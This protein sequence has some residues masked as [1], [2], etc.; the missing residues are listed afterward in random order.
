[1]TDEEIKQL[2][3]KRKKLIS[4]RRISNPNGE[5]RHSHRQRKYQSRSQTSKCD[6]KR[7]LKKNKGITELD[8]RNR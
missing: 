5:E 2:Q 7:N 4:F 3:N 8:K 6:F 1:M